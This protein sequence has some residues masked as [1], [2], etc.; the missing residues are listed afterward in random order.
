MTACNAITNAKTMKIYRLGNKLIGITG[1]K[2]Q[3]ITFK[4]VK[5]TLQER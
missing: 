5:T 2:R 4:L 3:P 1:K